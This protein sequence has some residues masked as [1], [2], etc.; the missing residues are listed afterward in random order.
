MGTQRF[1]FRAGF[2]VA[3][4]TPDLAIRPCV[5][6][7]HAASG[8]RD[9]LE[10]GALVL[11]VADEDPVAL[12]CADRFQFGTGVLDRVG[13]ASLL[14]DGRVLVLCSGVPTTPECGPDPA[15]V[16]RVAR[17][18]GDAVRRAAAELV[19]CRLGWG[20]MQVSVPGGPDLRVNL[21][22]IERAEST[23]T[24]VCAA[25]S[26]GRP[27]VGL[28]EPLVSAGW[29]GEVRRALPWPSLFLPGFPD[30]PEVCDPVALPGGVA[31]SVRRLWDRTTTSPSGA[32]AWRGMD[33]ATKALRA[34][35]IGNRRVAFWPGEPPGTAELPEDCVSL[36]GA[37][38]SS[39]EEAVSAMREGL[40]QV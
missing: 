22:K 16:G 24:P 31:A 14:P 37:G 39:G 20:T 7:G 17:E 40:A 6:D 10:V 13:G 4:I 35:R 8:V 15:D 30:V 27:A 18:V 3:D 28:G 38:A 29:V 9:P 23:R 33:L 21:L 1:H 2:A 5:L 26:L 19:P 11:G 25:F 34:G 36:V 12:I 32:W